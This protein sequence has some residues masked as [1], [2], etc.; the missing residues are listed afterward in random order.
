MPTLGSQKLIV[1]KPHLHLSRFVQRGQR[2]ENS[3]VVQV[4]LRRVVHH[5]AQAGS[6]ALKHL[7]TCGRR[8]CGFQRSLANVAQ[9]L[10][11]VSGSFGQCSPVV[12]LAVAGTKVGVV[13]RRQPRQGFQPGVQVYCEGNDVLVQN[14]RGKNPSEQ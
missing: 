14:L 4:M 13:E 2:R 3:H 1:L 5:Q 10:G 9:A 11:V 8:G 7:L 12:S 6:H